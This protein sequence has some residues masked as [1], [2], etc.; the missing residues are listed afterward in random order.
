MR[1]SIYEAAGGWPAFGALAEAHHRRCLAD[2]VLAHPFSHGVHPDHVERLAA[3]W[4]EVLGGPPRFSTEFGGESA[5]LWMHAGHD[6]EA[7]L[8]TRFVAC[9]VDSFDEAGIPADVELRD[10]LHA[11]MEWAVAAVMVYSP[12]GSQVPA[13]LAVPRWSWEG[14]VA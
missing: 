6:M 1:P 14:P 13:E 5:M 11:Y 4:A 8:G 3:Y 10:A 9:F 7:D 2:P 12:G